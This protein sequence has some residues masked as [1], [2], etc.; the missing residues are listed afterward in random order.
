MTK[1]LEELKDEQCPWHRLEDN[2][3]IWMSGFNACYAAIEKTHVPKDAL[4]K[5][6]EQRDEIVNDYFVEYPDVDDRIES[7]NKELDDILKL[8]IE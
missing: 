7:F 4:E 8:V 1:E 3:Q 2:R 6:K 5:C